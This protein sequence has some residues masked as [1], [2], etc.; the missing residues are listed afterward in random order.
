[1][2]LRKNPPVSYESLQYTI[3]KK[4]IPKIKATTEFKV[5]KTKDGRKIDLTSD[6]INVLFGKIYTSID[7]L[8]A[9][10]ESNG[11]KKADP[12][13]VQPTPQPMQKK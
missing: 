4:E 8:S 1:M 2:F 5:Y 9:P 3:P 7:G 6:N 10:E 11:G 13:N 12:D